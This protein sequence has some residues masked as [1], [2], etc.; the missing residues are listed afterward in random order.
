MLLWRGS[1]APLC[2][3]LLLRL[4]ALALVEG[5][6]VVRRA[7]WRGISVGLTIGLRH[8]VGGVYAEGWRSM[9]VLLGVAV[10]RLVGGICVGGGSGECVA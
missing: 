4:G 9:R 8:S 5:Q 10:S 6:L 1:C 7:S 3:L 2:L